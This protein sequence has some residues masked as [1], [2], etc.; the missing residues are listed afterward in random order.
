LLLAIGAGTGT[1]NIMRCF[2]WPVNAYSE[3]AGMFI[4]TMNAVLFWQ[5]DSFGLEGSWPLIV[6]V[7]ITTVGWVA[8]TLLTRPTDKATL[9]KF[10]AVTNPGGP[11]WKKVYREAEAEGNPIE[12]LHPEANIQ[13][14]LICMALACAAVYGFLF[15][16]GYFIYGKTA[17]AIVCFLVTLISSFLVYKLWFCTEEQEAAKFDHKD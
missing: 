2:C 11:G 8:I 9:R 14:G 4:A 3:I 12:F 5:F 10:V 15:G 7:V 16:T 13:R 17:T 1:I 6:S